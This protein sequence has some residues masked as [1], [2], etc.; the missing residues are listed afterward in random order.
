[1]LQYA[2]TRHN[3]NNKKLH[4]KKCKRKFFGLEEMIPDGNPGLQK[5]GKKQEKNV[6]YSVIRIKKGQLFGQSI[7]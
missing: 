4:C 1:M 5:E 6:N 3:N 7:G 2:H